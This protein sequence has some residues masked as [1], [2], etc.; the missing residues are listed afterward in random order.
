[1][2]QQ[3]PRE[4]QDGQVGEQ[5]NMLSD[6]VTG[7]RRRAGALLASNLDEITPGD[8]ALFTAYIERGTDGRHLMINTTTGDWYLL[9]KDYSKFVN[10]GQSD[11]LKCSI[12]ATSIQITTIAGLTYILNTFLFF[13]A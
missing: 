9:A 4:R 3:I 11:Y 13:S 10:S 1:M 6:P 7:I 12:G 8:D 5:L 2:S